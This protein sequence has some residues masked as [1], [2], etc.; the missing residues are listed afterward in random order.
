M[1]TLSE[2]VSEIKKAKNIAVVLHCSPDGDAIGSALALKEGLKSHEVTIVSS[3]DVPAIFETICGKVVAANKL[4]E[5][6]DLIILPDVS[7]LHRTGFAGIISKSSLRNKVMIIDHH[8]TGDLAK[9]IK[10]VFRDNEAV[11]TT[12]MIDRVFSELDRKSVV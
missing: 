8:K 11:S 5:N 1:A 6:F 2:I 9:N 4:S 3:E 7:E 10:L 12:E